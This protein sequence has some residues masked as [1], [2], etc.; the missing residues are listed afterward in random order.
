MTAEAAPALPPPRHSPSAGVIDAEYVAIDS[1]VPGDRS[2]GAL[3][4]RR[5]DN[6]PSLETLRPLRPDKVAPFSRRGGLRFWSLG[7]ALALLCFWV[8]G[9]HALLHGRPA[10]PAHASAGL[11]LTMRDSGIRPVGGRS[12]LAVEAEIANAAATTL[13]APPV[14]V[15][16]VTGDGITMRY[17]LTGAGTAIPPGG[18]QRFA[19]RLAMPPGGVRSVSVAFAS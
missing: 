9:G 11:V 14:A 13:E 5:P 17:M 6:P 19:S 16:I 7:L 2:T 4:R 10:S 3:T 12:V 8:S 1:P 18:R 15:L